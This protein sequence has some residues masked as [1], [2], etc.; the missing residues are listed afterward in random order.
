LT[1]RRWSRL[2]T[3]RRI[4]KPLELRR[5]PPRRKIS[6]PPRTDLRRL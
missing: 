1:C 2:V 6:P 5:R 4:E 3:G